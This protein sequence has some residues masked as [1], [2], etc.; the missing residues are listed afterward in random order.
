MS[1]TLS[2]EQ[3]DRI[4]RKIDRLNG[5]VAVRTRVNHYLAPDNA[6]VMYDGGTSELTVISGRVLSQP[7]VLRALAG[8][9]RDW[10]RMHFNFR[11]PSRD[12][13]LPAWIPSMILPLGFNRTKEQQARRL[14]AWNRRC[15]I[16]GK[17]QDRH[18]V[19]VVPRHWAL[20][21]R[22]ILAWRQHRW[23]IEEFFIRIGLYRSPVEGDWYEN[24]H[25]DPPDLWG[26]PI[27]RHEHFG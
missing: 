18:A 27:R 9:F 7:E 19:V 15:A 17:C 8:W 24:Y 25:F 2:I 16:V 12:Y 5:G 3:L 1:D 14:A 21:A 6:Y 23:L 13:R 10:P 4:E 11:L 26:T 20:A 22:A